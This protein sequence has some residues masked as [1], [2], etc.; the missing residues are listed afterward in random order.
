[1]TYRT[2]PLGSV[3]RL[4]GGGT[5]SKANSASYGGNIPWAT[6]RDMKAD[7]I[8]ETELS[9]TEEAVRTSATN[10]LPAGTVVIATRVG[11]GKVCIVERATAINQDL[12]G[13]VPFKADEV[14][15]R[16]L[17]W[18]LKS[19]AH[20]IVAQGTGATVQGVKTPFVASL[21][22]PKIAMAEQQ[23]I[24]AI[25]DETFGGIAA[26]A[27]RTEAALENAVSLS[28]ATIE[29]LAASDGAN[30]SVR[31]VGELIGQG[32]LERISDGNH[33]EIHPT[34]DEF[35][36]QGVP[37]VMAS[38]L[39]D[40]RVD[41]EGCRFIS[42]ARA[43][44]LRVGFARD[45]DVLLSH[46]GTIGR[47][48]ILSTG[49][50]YVMLTPQVT[51]YRVKDRTTLLP[52]YLYYALRGRKFQEQL[53]E[54]AGLGSTRAYIGIT[55]QLDLLLTIPSIGE[56]ERLATIFDQVDREVQL[57]ERALT[58]K[59]ALLAEL[60]Q[61]LLARAFSGELTREP[62]AA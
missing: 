62:I 53:R 13:L 37:F 18:W 32:V 23:R 1:M 43:R 35:V 2:V 60:K 50:P 15:S 24:V 46:K 34:K 5:P 33:G 38:D 52:Q 41:Q 27:S 40:G 7:L 17:F 49:R 3:C 61:S 47:V 51:Y 4:I 39:R 36:P 56:Q 14:H 31:S 19:I 22:F 6:V 25:L 8:S 44:S 48:A 54:I 12:R 9:I 57:L 28:A 10:I 20:L 55:R 59:L 16:F 26:T 21:P 42:E 29:S 45:G 58:G 11:L 30:T